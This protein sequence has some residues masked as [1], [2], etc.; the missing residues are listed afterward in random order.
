M[1][2][3]LVGVHKVKVKLA[4]GELGYYFY[5]WRGGPRMTSKPG[6]PAFTQ[7]YVRLTKDRKK[8]EAKPETLSWLIKQYTSSADY[9]KLSPSTK[10]DYE[11]MTGEILVRFGTLP[12][13]A[14]EAR[15]ARRLFMD[16]RDEMRSIPRCA[17][18]HITVLAR[19]LSWAKN[20]EIIVRNPLE[21][22]GKLHKSSRKDIIWM[23]SQVNKF[24]NEAAPHLAD[25]VRMALWTMQRKGDLLGLTTIAYSDG[26]LWIT[27][28][29]TGARVRIKPADEILPMLRKAKDANRKRVLVN[30]F[31]DIW[32]SSGF[33]SSFG[34][35]M[36]RLEISGV[37]FHDLRGTAITYAYAHGMDI[38]RIAEISGHSKS[39]CKVIIR[40]NYLASGDVIEAIRKGTK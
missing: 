26:L 29:K 36:K 23:P 8:A 37:T 28:G 20:R 5:A 40:K 19:M 22:A 35:E 17:D 21:R 9:Q 38:E 25:V 2:F 27:H 12:I 30:S 6:T 39:E 13:P 32:T 7:E 4:N 24:L 15:G 1:K 3:N 34:K 14:L 11:R 16:W 18:L 10:R 31:G 33:N